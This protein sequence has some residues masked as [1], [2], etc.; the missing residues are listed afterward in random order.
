MIK[1][2]KFYIDEIDNLY[3]FGLY[4]NNNNSQ[5]IGRSIGY[6]TYKL[7][8][9]KLDQFRLF[10]KNKKENAFE[11]I[12]ENGKF[13]FF[14]KEN[15]FLLKFYRSVPYCK[16]ENCLNAIKLIIK[17]YDAPIKERE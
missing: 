9:S 8:K 14:L 17:N 11:I 1:S 15:D 4:P 5:D 6:E 3:Y 7:A 12:K 10:I 13:K 2:Y 16:K